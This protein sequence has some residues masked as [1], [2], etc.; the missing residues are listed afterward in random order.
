MFKNKNKELSLTLKQ[1]NNL[2]NYYKVKTL[3]FKF[4]VYLFPLICTI[5]MVSSML[6]CYH[7]YQSYSQVIAEKPTE[8]IKLNKDIADLN[9][10]ITDLENLN[11][12]VVDKLSQGSN[13]SAEQKL[14]LFN[15]TPGFSN[16]ISRKYATVE[17]FNNNIKGNNITF[18]F[19]ISNNKV[20][21]EKLA[22]YIN[23]V[24]TTENEAQYF[25]DGL[26][27]SKTQQIPFNRGERF[28]IS[29]FRSVETSFKRP[30]KGN[31]AWYNIFI[32]ARNGDL[33]YNSIQGPYY[34]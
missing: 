4:I 1:G 34:Y 15:Q 33:I 23:V 5:M 30:H 31:K 22:G 3:P 14:L 8:I 27:D 11:K 7:Y 28:T 6:A 9:L 24:Q 29:R 25:P 21:G 2:P 32:F 10:K 18:T 12:N 13:K 16:L 19:D 26:L 20:G 17:N